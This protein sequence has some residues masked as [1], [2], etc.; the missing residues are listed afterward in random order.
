MT[1]P[2]PEAGLNDTLVNPSSQSQQV[3]VPGDARRSTVLPRLQWTGPVPTASPTQRLRFEEL[4]PLGRG[5][6][7]EVVL[8]KDHDIERTVAI[9]RL[10]EQQD[11]GLLMRFVDEI[12]TVGALEHPN[13]VPVHDVGIDER[14]R[15]YFVM[16]HLRGESLESIIE[17]LKAGDAAAHAR[18]PFH[19][20]VQV[21]LG[22]L[23]AMAY[24]HQQGFIHRDLKPANIM[25]GPWGEVTVM[26]WG[27]ARHQATS[28]T[29][30]VASAR[31][32]TALETKVGAVMGT[33]LYMSPEQARGEQD[34]LDVRSDVYSLTVLF[35]EFL[36][37]EHYLGALTALPEILSAVQTQQ[38]ALFS[39]KTN[40]HQPAV[41][42]ELG[43]YLDRGFQK[44]PAK[45]F[46]SAQEMI[47]A[48]QR[49]IDGRVEVHC[50]R[51]FTKRMLQEAV[52]AADAHPTLVIVGST[53]VLALV[54]A[55]LVN[56][57]LTFF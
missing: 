53:A 27:L 1:D 41:P 17:R 52:H 16:K 26:D 3:T 14:G 55:G 36:Y 22:V 30:P 54:L 57:F 2:H 28:D 6:M 12:R 19:V 43:W 50:Q 35:H 4:G 15:Y 39:M 46:Q 5:G 25:V 44:D 51:T 42:A 38:P 49:I 37:L 7:G 8:A 18:F 13:I 9:K 10:T 34:K 23:N 21:F 11:L 45:R 20:R 48:L 33:P 56:S 24:A 31:V 40:P 47:D 32:G 29:L